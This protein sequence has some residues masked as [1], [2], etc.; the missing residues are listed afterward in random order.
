MMQ[1]RFETK[2]KNDYITLQ[3][4]VQSAEFTVYTKCG[5]FEL[6]GWPVLLSNVQTTFQLLMDTVYLLFW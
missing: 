4:Y 3:H 6:A 2:S 5:Q 1:K